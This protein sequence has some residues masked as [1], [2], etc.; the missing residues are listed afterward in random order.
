MNPVIL[1]EHLTR[2]F[3][4]FVA[5]DDVSFAV[6]AG[7]VVGCLGPNGSGKTTTIRMLLGL[8]RPS[9]GAARVL[10]FDCV[11]QA[12]ALR[13]R[14]GYMSQK[15]AL[16]QELTAREN[17]AFYA[18][19][20]GVTERSRVTEILAELEL[21]PAADQPAQALSAGWK[22]RLALATALVHRPS[23]LILDEP[24]SGVDPVARRTF[25]NLI[26]DRA[27]QGITVLVTTHYMDEAEYCER[28][29]VMR[30]GRLLALDTPAALKAGLPGPVWQ[31]AAAPLDTALAALRALPGVLRVGLDSDTL[32]VIT[33]PEVTAADLQRALT[34]AGASASQVAPAAPTLEDVFLMLAG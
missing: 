4:D 17:L 6:E 9:A 31:T 7:Q 27:A 21:T 1:A 22:Q 20:Y 15:F 3:G 29:A 26:Y 34:A 14:V 23:L 10:G 8:L 12:E 18:G 13:A 2:R 19:L 11:S 24:T 30:S 32:R 28:L 33:R 5:V 25:W 16:Y